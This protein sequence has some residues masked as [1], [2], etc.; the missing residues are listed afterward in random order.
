MNYRKSVL[1]PSE[2]TDVTQTAY[3]LPQWKQDDNTMQTTI[4]PPQVTHDLVPICP[5]ESAVSIDLRE[6]ESND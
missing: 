5:L 1:L 3:F 4:S 2:L 6:S